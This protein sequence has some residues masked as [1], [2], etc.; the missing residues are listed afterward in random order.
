MESHLATLAEQAASRGRP[1]S[2][3]VLD[4]TTS[5]RSTTPPA[6]TPATTCYPRTRVRKSISGIDLAC[7]YGGEQFVIVMPET[8]GH[9]GRAAA[10]L[11]AGEPFTINE[12]HQRIELTISIGLS[13]LERKGEPS[14]A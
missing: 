10:P 6:T 5:N 12:G 7:R 14:Q 8:C 4:I 1:I 3:M 2:L 9:G 11:H 13:T